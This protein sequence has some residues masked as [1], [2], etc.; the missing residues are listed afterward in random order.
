MVSFWLEGDL[1]MMSK[2]N[3]I[4]SM[5]VLPLIFSFC[6]VG[7]AR[8]KHHGSSVD[9]QPTPSMKPLSFTVNS[10]IT[11]ADCADAMKI[12]PCK[13]NIV[14]GRRR[15]IASPLGS[16]PCHA[17]EGYSKEP[18]QAGDVVV[19][20]GNA[21]SARALKS[22]DGFYTFRQVETTLKYG[23]VELV[24]GRNGE[25]SELS[26]QGT[27]LSGK[28]DATNKRAYQSIVFGEDK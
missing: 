6:H 10:I 24:Y 18:L 1:T 16:P 17:L 15:A 26:Y 7:V 27:M 19:C 12:N 21:C 13:T 23:V 20:K 22:P 14:S 4:K 9:R 2:R 11:S 3:L 28:P 8:P 5:V 25:E